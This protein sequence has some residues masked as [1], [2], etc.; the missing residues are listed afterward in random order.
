LG[1]TRILSAIW[2]RI[3]LGLVGLDVRMN[4][5]FIVYGLPLVVALGLGSPALAEETQPETQVIPLAGSWCWNIKAPG[6]HRM[7]TQPTTRLRP[8]KA[9]LDSEENLLHESMS[10]LRSPIVD[11][12]PVPNHSPGFAVVGTGMEALQHAHD[13]W[14]RKEPVKTEL[15]ADTDLSLVIRTA[16]DI[17]VLLSLTKEN[18]RPGGIGQ[19]FEL[20]Y[21]WPYVQTTEERVMSGPRI[22]WAGIALIPIGKLP[23]GKYEVRITRVPYEP[24]SGETLIPIPPDWNDLII[25]QPFV[26]E[27][28]ENEQATPPKMAARNE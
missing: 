9:Y 7:F 11:S 22:D 2:P 10:A 5:L 25:C 8:D 26:F 19:S 18:L 28:K 21:Q 6:M 4:W 12:K 15:P 14:V 17:A 24:K 27:V 23:V 16:G 3:V 13:I 1:V 20:K